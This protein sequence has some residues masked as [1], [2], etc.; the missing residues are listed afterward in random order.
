MS[1]VWDG[2]CVFAYPRTNLSSSLRSFTV[3]DYTRKP[4]KSHYTA[5]ITNPQTISS[6]TATSSQLSPPT[7]VSSR[8]GTPSEKTQLHSA[9]GLDIEA[10][11]ADGGAYGL[12]HDPRLDGGSIH[13]P[14]HD[15]EMATLVSGVC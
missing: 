15:V 10:Q 12:S 14:S 6:L 7:V 3:F 13:R 11:I 5:A 4:R 9:T 8:P 2:S 1:V